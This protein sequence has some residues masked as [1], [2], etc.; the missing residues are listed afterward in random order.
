MQFG[1]LLGSDAAIDLEQT[2]SISNDSV[3]PLELMVV[4]VA[5][6]MPSKLALIQQPRPA[7]K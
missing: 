3:A 1:V 5:R 6:D 2:S 4:G 7:R